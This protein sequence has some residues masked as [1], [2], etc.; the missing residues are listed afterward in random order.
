MSESKIHLSSIFDGWEGYNTSLLHAIQPLT[1]EQLA[2]RPAAGLRSVG[3]AAGHIALGR[4][5]WF[6]R[7][8]APGSL[9]LWEQVVALGGEDAI[10]GD[11]AA[12]LHWL[13]ASWGMIAKT[14]AQWTVAD[15]ARAFRQEYQGATYAVSYQWATWRILTHDVHHG[16]EL[17]LMLGMQGMAVPELGDLFGHI[18]MP[19]LAGEA[20]GGM[21]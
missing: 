18:T 21:Q 13:E 4:V 1:D 20:G 19:P 5:A 6:A 10:A 14:L 11:K 12:I 16:G 9:E 7:M 15:L 3:E 17:A 2:W 8:A